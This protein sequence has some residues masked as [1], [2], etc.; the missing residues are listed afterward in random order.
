MND[1]VEILGIPIDNVNS[2]DAVQIS[3]N[4]IDYSSNKII[5]TPNSE[6]LLYASMEPELKKIIKSADMVVPDGAGVILASKILG[7]GLKERVPGVDLVKSLLDLGNEKGYRFYFLGGTR[8]VAKKVKER[9]SKDFPG[10]S[11]K[12]HHGYFDKEAEKDIIKELKEE[13]IEVLLVGMGTPRQEKWLSQ[14]LPEL[15]V[16][17]SMGVGGSFDVLVGEKKRAPL[18][19]QNLNLEWL[20]RLL[21][22]PKRVWRMKALPVFIIKVFTERIK[23]MFSNLR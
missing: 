2:A 20:Y 23:K 15:N 16:S 21:Q 17:V 12:A 10:I 22:E 3:K 13:E 14:H 18:V 5:I 8:E 4:F 11:I 19:M 9:V 7:N 1:K 6:M